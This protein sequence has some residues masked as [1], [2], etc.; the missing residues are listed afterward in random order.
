MA[1]RQRQQEGDLLPGLVK[2]HVAKFE[3]GQEMKDVSRNNGMVET[4]SPAAP[5]VDI[6]TNIKLLH[7]ILEKDRKMM[8]ENL[9]ALEE[10]RKMMAENRQAMEENRMLMAENCQAM[11]QHRYSLEGCLVSLHLG[12]QQVSLRLAS[13]ISHLDNRVSQLIELVNKNND[14]FNDLKHLL[15]NQVVQSRDLPLD[16]TKSSANDQNGQL[17]QKCLSLPVASK[18]L[19]QC[20]SCGESSTSTLNTNHGVL[21]VQGN[22]QP[23]VLETR[24]DETLNN[25][26]DGE[27]PFNMEQY[28]H[29]L[30]HLRSH[31]Y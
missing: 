5:S 15:I 7:K 16:G 21:H 8:V 26:R 11:E 12:A 20:D 24:S 31:P 9:Q 3:F 17:W 22:V 6:T 14:D 1:P 27:D 2:K 29:M 28:H 18:P 30:A 25:G 10:N 13:L 19:P 23:L 4:S